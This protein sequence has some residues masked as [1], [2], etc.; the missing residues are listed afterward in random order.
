MQDVE[1]LGSQHVGHLA[2]I[3]VA[4]RRPGDASSAEQGNGVSDA[5]HAVSLVLDS[6][7][8]GGRG[9][10]AIAYLGGEDADVVPHLL[11]RVREMVYVLLSSAEGWVVVL[12]DDADFRGEAAS[13][14]GSHSRED[15]EVSA[16]N[17]FFLRCRRGPW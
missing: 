15:G 17:V 2:R 16:A 6:P 14:D 12:G 11:G 10:Q 5:D 3:P 13:Q 4:H 8:A 9:G 7:G 1:A